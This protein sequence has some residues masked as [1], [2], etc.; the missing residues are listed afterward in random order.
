MKVENSLQGIKISDMQIV[1]DYT[2]EAHRKKCLEIE[3][4]GTTLNN[5]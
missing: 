5:I 4:E 1:L 3:I 2:E